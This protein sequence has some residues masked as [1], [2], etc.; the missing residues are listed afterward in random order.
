[1][2]YFILRLYSS[3]EP[4]WLTQG[5]PNHLLNVI[6]HIVDTFAET[7]NMVTINE[8]YDKQKFLRTILDSCT[9]I[10]YEL[11]TTTHIIIFLQATIQCSL[12]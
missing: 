2:K 6:A 3:N 11:F 10:D 8:R 5:C 7:P 4:I 12:S 9:L 1:M